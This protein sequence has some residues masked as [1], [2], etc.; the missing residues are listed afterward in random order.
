M[1]RR[2][3]RIVLPYGLGWTPL[4]KK[5]NRRRFCLQVARDSIFPI[6]GYQR[7]KK[8]RKVGEEIYY[9]NRSRTKDARDMNCNLGEKRSGLSFSSL[10][11]ANSSIRARRVGG[12]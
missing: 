1:R 10:R 7:R 9:K 12:I 5:S 4:K 3:V 2:G 6:Y 11:K 8:R